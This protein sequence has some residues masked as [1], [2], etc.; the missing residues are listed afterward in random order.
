MHNYNT[1]DGNDSASSYT[2]GTTYDVS[3]FINGKGVID[4]IV[5]G[6]RLPDNAS[7][8]PDV[9]QHPRQEKRSA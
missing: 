7:A 5:S 3:V 2:Q 1:G 4:A 8:L 6:A 9:A